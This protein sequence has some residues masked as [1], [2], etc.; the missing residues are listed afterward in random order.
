MTAANFLPS[1]AKVLVYEGG[2]SN[3]AGDPGGPTMWGITH[4]DYDAY[5]K[6]KGLPTQDVRQMTT[7]ERDEIYHDKYWARPR[8]DELPSGPDFVVFDGAVNS[9]IAQSLKWLQRAV[10]V[11]AD[12]AM[13]DVTMAATIT[14]P[15]KSELVNKMC[16]QR[17]VFLQALRTWSRFGIGWGRRVDN[18]RSYGLS[19]VV[20]DAGGVP[21]A[22]GGGKAIGDDVPVTEDFSAKA[23][24]SD[25]NKT[26]VSPEI[27]TTVATGSGLGSGLTQQLQS[28]TE[29]LR[30][31]S[32]TI[33][34][35]G[36]I[37]AAVAVIGAF[38]TIYALWKRNKTNKAVA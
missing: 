1:L 10:G 31:L 26:T 30:P 25:A 6:V 37:L 19:L 13:G 33:R 4:I 23:R 24:A 36:Y 7:A 32:Y 35:I 22:D 34:W 11:P 14:Y 3:D 20:P 16:D 5:R 9:G 2:Y 8:C 12:G 18:V 28:L 27:S 38:Y 29:P 17:L 21:V 15:D